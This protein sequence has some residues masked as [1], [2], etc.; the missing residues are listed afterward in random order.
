MT[1][2][3]SLQ[4]LANDVKPIEALLDLLR[5][6]DLWPRL[7]GGHIRDRLLGSNSADIDIATALTPDQVLTRLSSRGITAIPTGIAHGTITC[8]YAG[9]QLEITTLRQD[10]SCDGRH[11]QVQ[12]SKDFLQDALR[13]DFT[14]N[15]LSYAPESGKIYDYTEGLQ[16]LQQQRVVFIGD[17]SA[18]IREDA[19]RIM[20]F[21]RFSALYAKRIDQEG[22]LATIEHKASLLTLSRERIIYEL[23]RL[24]RAPK[25]I[26][27]LHLMQES[28]VLEVLFAAPPD[29]N[30]LDHGFKIASALHIEL[31]MESI[32]SILFKSVKPEELAELL[33]YN[34]FSRAA[35][36]KILAYNSALNSNKDFAAELKRYW[37]DYPTNFEQYLVI[38]VLAGLISYDDA[39]DLKTYVAREPL[40]M[41]VSGGELKDLGYQGAQIRQALDFL[42]Q[43]WID[44]DF[45]LTKEQL[46]SLIGK[47][48]NIE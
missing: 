6:G 9:Q 20:R 30:A 16:H 12:F 8:I 36:N 39:I 47:Q 48:P 37:L 18:R 41:P 21:Y 5:D 32:Y 35:K 26:D 25:A 11:A 7:V 4:A 29:I 1:P 10:I 3:N 34:R 44:S 2:D 17:P 46:I 24:L 40:S 38:G 14:I 27:T 45:Q 19:L 43:R 42:K 28:G 33:K 23:H 15:A 31:S 13:R 22:Y